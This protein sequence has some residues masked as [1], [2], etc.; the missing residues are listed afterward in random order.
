MSPEMH[1]KELEEALRYRRTPRGRAARLHSGAKARARN[2]GVE[3]A[4]TVEWIQAKIEEGHCEVSG[5]PFD[6]RNGRRPFA[7]SLDRTDPNKGYTADNVKVVVWCYNAAKGTATHSDV[8]TLAEA[9]CT[10]K[11]S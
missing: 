2:V 1:Q 8:L 3:F 9:L 6:L 4:L 11:K 5:L 7:P 10:V